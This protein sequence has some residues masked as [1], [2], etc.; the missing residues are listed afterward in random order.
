MAVTLTRF[1][2]AE[3]KDQVA[4]LATVAGLTTAEMRRVDYEYTIAEGDTANVARIQREITLEYSPPGAPPNS[5]TI[6]FY[7]WGQKDVTVRFTYT[8]KGAAVETTY[9]MIVLDIRLIMELADKDR[10]KIT[11]GMTNEELAKHRSA[12]T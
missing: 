8:A 9:N 6:D 4:S 3:G 5:A 7:D 11:L 2:I 10:Y 12:A 1:K